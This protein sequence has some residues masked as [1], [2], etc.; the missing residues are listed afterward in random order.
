VTLAGTNLSA[1]EYSAAQHLLWIH[2]E[3]TAAPR[4]LSVNF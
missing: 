2:F 4:E 3:N 1:F